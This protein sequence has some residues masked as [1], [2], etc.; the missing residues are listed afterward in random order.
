M[1]Y[2][3]SEHIGGSLAIG[4]KVV[5]LNLE[6]GEQ[7][8]DESVA[9]ILMSQKLVTPVAEPAKVKKTPKPKE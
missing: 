4:E 3:V 5:P 7:E 1:K 2:N 8:L 6:P 9:R